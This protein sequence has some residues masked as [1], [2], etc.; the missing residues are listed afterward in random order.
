MQPRTGPN[1]D[2]LI[3]YLSNFDITTVMDQELDMYDGMSNPLMEGITELSIFE[4]V[5]RHLPPELW[6][7]WATDRSYIKNWVKSK[8]L[9]RFKSSEASSLWFSGSVYENY[10]TT[11]GF[12]LRLGTTRILTEVQ[13][14]EIEKILS[15]IGLSLPGETPKMPEA[16][17]AENREIMGSVFKMMAREH[18][19]IA[20]RLFKER[21][22]LANKSPEIS[23]AEFVRKMEAH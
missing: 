9:I 21:L 10:Y 19:K 7:S 22:A 3:Q 16:T 20:Y 15:K 11:P 13:Y 2:K 17:D 8:E 23:Y 18:P 12:L 4:I 14:N 1:H 5:D 6:I